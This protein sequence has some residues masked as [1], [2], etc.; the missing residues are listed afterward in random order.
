[1]SQ[2]SYEKYFTSYVENFEQYLR[3]FFELQKSD[4][5][6]LKDLIDS[7]KYSFQGGGKRFRPVL[8]QLTAEALIN[9]AQRVLPFG[10]AVEMIHTYSL[11]HDDLP[12]MDDDDV[13]R[14]LPTNHKV[15]GEATALLAG[16][17]LQALAFQVIV[18]HFDESPKEALRCLK[19]F[20]RAVGQSGMVGGQAIDMFGQKEQVD[21][22]TLEHMHRWKT[23]AL[24]ETACV[25]A[26]YLLG[27]PD[28]KVAQLA[29][30][31]RDLGLAF[32]VAD[33][34]LD[35]D[36]E[37]PELQ[38]YTSVLGLES[39]RSYLHDLS[40]QALQTLEYW[41][42]SAEGLRQMVHYNLMRLK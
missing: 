32:Q 14:G 36:P 26:A 29:Q 19:H 10:L 34:L 5:Q 9:D 11:I 41:G 28:E 30:Y 3:S 8:A 39:T 40:A 17:A 42:E 31:S 7:M 21:Q 13:R 20:S 6:G 4:V 27:A 24:I 12:C 23:G 18:D 33:D 37:T 2:I 1:M 22:Q 25:G 38:S 16:D 15:F 35:Y